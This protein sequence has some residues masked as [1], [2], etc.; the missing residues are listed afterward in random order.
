MLKCVSSIPPNF[1]S[2][3]CKLVL[4]HLVSGSNTKS[5][6]SMLCLESLEKYSL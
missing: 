3:I 5:H 4:R 6:K 2:L 1:F